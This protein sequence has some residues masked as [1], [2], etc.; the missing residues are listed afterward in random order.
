MSAQSSDSALENGS[1]CDEDADFAGD[2]RGV[3]DD[4]GNNFINSSGHHWS[5]NN[6]NKNN[7]NKTDYLSPRQLLAE[8]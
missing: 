3:S 1:A 5:N 2:A 6:H 4:L 8:Q 7:H